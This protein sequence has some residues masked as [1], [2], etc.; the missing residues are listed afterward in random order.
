MAKRSN[1]K[2]IGGFV[3][4]AIALSVVGLLAFGGGQYFKPKIRGV[5]YFEGSLSGLEVG[6]PVTFRGIKIGQVTNIVIHYDVSKQTLLIPIYVD[7]E[8]D[9]VE[10]VSGERSTKNLGALV[11]RGLRAQLQVQSLVTGQVSIDFDFHPETPV[12]LVG[13]DPTVPELP[14]IPSSMDVLKAS[15]TSLLNKV[16]QLPLDEIANGILTT[17]HD[18]DQT[19]KEARQAIVDARA[20]LENVNAQVQPLSNSLI[21]TSNQANK[22]FVDAQKLIEDADGDLPKLVNAAL[23]VMSKADAALDQADATLRGAQRFLKPDSPVYVE[24]T[25]TLQ[26]L[27]ATA[28]AIRAFAEYLQRNPN[29]LLTG[30]K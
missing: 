25:Q 21:G 14:T 3:V 23:T 16:N 18:S 10:V 30:K 29:A 20:L 17:V 8:P 28:S 1:P 13:G 4:G 19:V 6:S 12:K 27:R 22:T 24:I 7:I 9:R 2:L 15:F 26:D 11:Q 5:M